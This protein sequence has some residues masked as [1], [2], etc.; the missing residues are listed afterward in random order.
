VSSLANRFYGWMRHPS[1]FSL[2]SD[3]GSVSGFE[4]LRSHKYCLLVT[5]KRDGQAVPTPVWFGLGD[6]KLYIRSEANAAKIKRIRNDPHVRIAPCTVRGRPLGAPADGLARVLETPGE[7]QIGEAC[8][9]ANY[10]LGR[11]AYEG[12]LGAGAV[13]LE[14]TPG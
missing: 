1:A 3:A 5:Y 9:K 12:T 13:Y 14:V 4:H 6:R 2:P 8:L 11:K 10:G 7:E